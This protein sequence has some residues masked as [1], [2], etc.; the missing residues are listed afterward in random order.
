MEMAVRS[1]NYATEKFRNLKGATMGK[2]FN[3][4][5]SYDRTYQKRTDKGGGGFVPY[6]FG[7]HSIETGEV[8]SIEIACNGCSYCVEKQQ[9]LKYKRMSV[10]QYHK[11]HE[12]HKEVSQAKD[13]SDF[14][15]V[16]LES[17]LARV[18]VRKSLDQG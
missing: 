17:K 4:S 14:N 3:V 2:F 5:V 11:W 12:N 6:F 15:S 7:N 18:I 16:A 9:A 10:E 8:L 1:C 13:F